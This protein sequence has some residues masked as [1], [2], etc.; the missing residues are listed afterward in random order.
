MEATG[1]YPVKRGK[2]GF[3]ETTKT[4]ANTREYHNLKQLA[5]QIKNQIHAKEHSYRPLN[6]GIKRLHQQM[7]YIS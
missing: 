3:R 5:V 4:M 1:V 2:T 7:K 6:S